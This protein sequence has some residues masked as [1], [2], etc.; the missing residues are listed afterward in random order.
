[1]GINE[2]VWKQVIAK[3]SP[4]SVFL[5]YQLVNTLW[6]NQNTVVQPGAHVPLV[7]AQL[8]PGASQE[9]VAN[10]TMETYVQNLTCLTCHQSAAVATIK[11]ATSVK[12]FDP[13]KAATAQNPYGSDYSFL[14]QSAKQPKKPA[15][16]N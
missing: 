1:V 14:F 16:G 4:N 5:N 3:Q 7:A 6:S 2:Y 8:S 13:S 12:I 11:P 15:G 9:P 10:T